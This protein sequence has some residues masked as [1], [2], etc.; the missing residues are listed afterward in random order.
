METARIITQDPTQNMG[1]VVR[2]TEEVLRGGRGTEKRR[3]MVLE[4]EGAQVLPASGPGRSCL[5]GLMMIRKGTLAALTMRENGDHQSVRVEGEEARI[6]VMMEATNAG[7]RRKLIL[8][9]FITA[10]PGSK[11]VLKTTRGMQGGKVKLPREQDSSLEGLEVVEMMVILNLLP[12]LLDQIGTLL[13]CWLRMAPD[14][15]LN[16]P[17]IRRVEITLSTW[18]ATLSTP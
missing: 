13:V 11:M 2:A 3:E 10:P 14:L 18:L 9:T 16:R 17:S 15:L 1:T 6:G 7:K 4:A 12:L 8:K 5:S